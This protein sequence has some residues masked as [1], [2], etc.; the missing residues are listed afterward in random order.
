MPYEQE[1]MEYS[2]LQWGLKRE[3]SDPEI[4]LSHLPTTFDQADS[5]P[6]TSG[7]LYWNL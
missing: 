2:F 3:D 4:N 6:D 5:I 7:R 1:S